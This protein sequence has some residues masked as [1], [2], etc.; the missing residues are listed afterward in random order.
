VQRSLRTHEIG[1][2]SRKFQVFKSRRYDDRQDQVA[3]R[4][5]RGNGQQ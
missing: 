5:E 3:D 2:G 4:R 1:F